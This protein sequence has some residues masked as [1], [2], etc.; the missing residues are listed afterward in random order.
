M[1]MS[2]GS[3]EV[4]FGDNPALYKSRCAVMLLY[5]NNASD[6]NTIKM[7]TF[8]PQLRQIFFFFFLTF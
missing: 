7:Y 2:S 5:K 4:G 6:F 8:C 1:M 3:L